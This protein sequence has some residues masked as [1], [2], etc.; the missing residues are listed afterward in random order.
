M[1]SLYT[2]FRQPTPETINSSPL[3]LGLFQSVSDA[4]A[5]IT[6]S[7][8]GDVHWCPPSPGHQRWEL[9]TGRYL[10]VVE[11]IPVHEHERKAD[12]ESPI[13][14]SP[15]DASESLIESIRQLATHVSEC[16]EESAAAARE[17]HENWMQQSLV[18]DDEQ[19]RRLQGNERFYLGQAAAFAW[20]A[21]CL[22]RSRAS[23]LTDGGSSRLEKLPEDD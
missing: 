7:C 4:Q 12:S 9:R 10:Y 23:R 17:S 11:E 8:S 21:G 18:A 3:V 5:Q 13:E 19:L 2:L 6:K 15:G 22:D 20:I 1:Q 16:L 14:S